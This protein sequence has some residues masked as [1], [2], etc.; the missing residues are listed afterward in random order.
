[1]TN[2]SQLLQQEEKLGYQSVHYIVKLK[3]TRSKLPE[4]GRFRN[5]VAEVQVRTILQH[6]WAEIEHDI[7]YKSIATLPRPIRRRF[8]TLAGL[9]E[10]A[11]R[12]FQAISDEETKLRLEARQSVAAGRLKEVEITPD[13]LKAYL[14]KR[15]G[16]DRRMSE[17]TYGWMAGIL[18]ALGFGD[19]EQV[20]QCVRN[21]NDDEISRIIWGGRMGQISR[22]DDVLLASMGE[23]YIL[24]H[25]WA[26]DEDLAFMERFVKRRRHRLALLEAAGIKIGLCRPVTPG[27]SM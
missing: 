17:W 10:I 1:V 2:K 21:Y 22:F 9:L 19:I 3:A 23:D 11:D 18:K 7:Q 25:P 20:D 26:S 13:A 24:R 5:L 15:Y 16:P 4:Y 12:E 14:D 8:I 6:T 27:R